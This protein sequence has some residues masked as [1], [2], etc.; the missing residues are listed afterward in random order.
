VWGRSLGLPIHRHRLFET[1]WPVMVAPCSGG[2]DPFGIYGKL[3][4]RRL[5]NRS[6]GTIYSAVGTLE[7]AQAAMEMPW[8]D[9][10][11]VR[12]AIPPRYTEEI[13]TQ[14]MSHLKAQAAA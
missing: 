13:G 2:R 6:D 3:D 7:E 8:A 1:N 14:L 9:W 5:W 11:G 10:D 4:G 12:E